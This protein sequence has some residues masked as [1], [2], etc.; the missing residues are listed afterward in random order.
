MAESKAKK[1]TGTETV[2]SVILTD[3]E[4]EAIPGAAASK[5]SKWDDDIQKVIDGHIVGI[6]VTKDTVKGIRIGIARRASKAFNVKFQFRHDESRGLL[7]V[8]LK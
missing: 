8:R 4:W 1:V 7:A 2:E 5:P 3:E 6:P